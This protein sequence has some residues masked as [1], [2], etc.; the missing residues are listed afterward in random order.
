MVAKIASVSRLQAVGFYFVFSR[1]SN[2][3]RKI[4]AGFVFFVETVIFSPPS[5]LEIFLRQGIGGLVL[6][7]ELGVFSRAQRP[8]TSGWLNWMAG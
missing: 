7:R 3:K 2:V 5:Q 4:H 8:H 1:V 6:H